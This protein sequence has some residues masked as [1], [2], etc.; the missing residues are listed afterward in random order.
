MKARTVWDH[1]ENACAEMLA[2]DPK[3]TALVVEKWPMAAPLKDWVYQRHAGA[4][5]SIVEMHVAVQLCAAMEGGL[6]AVV[7]AKFGQTPSPDREIDANRSKLR[8][9]PAPFYATF[10]PGLEVGMLCCD[11]EFGWSEPVEADLAGGP[12]TLPPMSVPLEVGLMPAAKML[13]GINQE[14]GFGLARWSYGYDAIVA[15]I[16]RPEEYARRH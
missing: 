3:M 2:K 1:A 4:V 12:I 11:G 16:P 14:R 6:V 8:D 5:P 10:D 13:Y 15:F 9:L 7:G